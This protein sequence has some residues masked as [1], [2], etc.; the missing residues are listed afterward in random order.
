[1]TRKQFVLMENRFY[2]KAS[3]SITKI[4]VRIT[5]DVIRSKLWLKINLL[6]K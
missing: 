5:L 4:L 3:K 2:V 6:T 1:M